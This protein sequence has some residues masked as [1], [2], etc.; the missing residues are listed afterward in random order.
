MKLRI[1]NLEF[2]YPSVPVLKDICMELHSGTIVSIVGRNGA[3]KSTLLK[4]MNRILQKDKGAIFLDEQLIE[5]MKIK[6]IARRMAYLP[7]TGEHDFSVTVFDMVLMGRYPHVAWSL[8]ES[9]KDFVW[10]VLQMMD[11]QE[12]AIRDFR[13]ISGGQQQQVLLARAL[14]QQADVFLLDEPTSNLDIR[15][16]L[17]VMEVLKKLVKESNILTVISIHDLNL[18][19]RY[20]DWVIMINQGGI[21]AAGKPNEVFTAENIQL[22]YG[23]EAKT[24]TA[25]NKVHIIP[26]RPLESVEQKV[27]K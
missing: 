18:A 26:V 13:H 6:E 21:Y 12:L 1:E 4:C 19:A 8:N 9:D 22:V 20:A 14:A 11:L 15:H 17:E 10:K 5:S 25:S 2:S 27:A 3:G 23:V 16:Q 7:Q 24:I